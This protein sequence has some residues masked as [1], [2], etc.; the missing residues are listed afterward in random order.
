[1]VHQG[2]DPRC[3]R[4]RRLEQRLAVAA[5]PAGV[6]IDRSRD[7]RILGGTGLGQ[8]ASF[9]CTALRLGL[10]SVDPSA[11]FTVG[12]TWLPPLTEPT[13][14]AAPGSASMSTST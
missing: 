11:N 13:K 2:R 6:D 9:A 1:M 12:T 8:A 5:A 14:S 3:A 4:E 10:V 7:H